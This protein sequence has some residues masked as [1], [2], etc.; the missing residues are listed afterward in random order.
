M[1]HSFPTRRPSDLRLRAQQGKPD[2]KTNEDI[3]QLDFEF[4][5]FASATIDYDYIMKLAAAI[6]MQPAG[7][8]SMSRDQLV[9]LIAGDA[10]FI[11]E[12]EEISEYVR[13]LRSEEHTSELQ[14]LMRISYAAFCMKKKT[15]HNEEH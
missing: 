6:S 2:G 13:G 9:G 4:V 8:A 12:R 15:K 10:K 11:D 1:T 5:L 14:S 7:K 3:D